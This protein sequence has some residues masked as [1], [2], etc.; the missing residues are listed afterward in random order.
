MKKTL[1]KIIICVLAAAA[2]A[3]PLY[4]LSPVSADAADHSAADATKFTFSGS[5]IT[6]QDGGC[7]DYRIDG[8]ALTIEGGGTYIVSG[9]CPDGSITVKKGVTGVTLVLDGLTLTSENTAPIACNKSSEVTIVAAAGTVSTLTDSEANNSE[10]YAENEDAESAVVKCK[11]G[12]NVT[13]CGSGTLN[14]TAVSKNG[15]KSGASSEE[16]G[17]ASLTIR[18]VTLNISTSANDAINAGQELNIESGALTIS[19]ADDAIHCDRVLNVGSD[20]AA[21]PSITVTD[22]YEG[23]EAAELNIFSGDIN[24]ISSDDC[25]NAA[26]SELTGYDFSMTI[27]GGS[28]SAYSSNGDGFDS[29]GDIT[30]SGGRVVV[31]TANTADN[32]PLDADGTLTVSGGTVLA[33]GG[34]AGM[35]VRIDAAQPYVI[36]GSAGGMGGGQPG[37][38]G[39]SSV[40]LLKDAAF[41][42]KDS[43][44]NTLLDETALCGADY[45]FFSSPELASG[46]SYTLCSGSDSIADGDAQTGSTSFGGPGGG[47]QPDG[48]QPGGGRQ[49]VSP[50]GS[51]GSQ[52]PT[53]PDDSGSPG[54][55]P[56]AAPRR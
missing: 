34:S 54:Q 7:T 30:V 28:V 41:S 38:H 39:G 56:D 20:G 46:E 8:T 1:P 9:S 11:D 43:A 55:P 15:I 17:S 53:P 21:G 32:Q 24:I 51:V 35:G 37:R 2:L 16:D 44:G 49:P 26:N 18:D 40:L 3:L 13:I 12:S 10:Y 33:A 45:V 31:W 23:L 42:I 14:I 50:G 25:L 29:N 5:T 27:S 19:A 47:K 6:A 36:F 4:L 22:C 52:P 48:Q